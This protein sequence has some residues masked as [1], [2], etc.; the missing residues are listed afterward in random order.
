M[1]ISAVG[2]NFN[3][4]AY[5]VSGPS[6]VAQSDA[7]DGFRQA[8]QNATQAQKDQFKGDMSAFFKA[9]Q[10]GDMNAAQQA[11]QAVKQDRAAIYSPAS[12]SSA[13]AASSTGSSPDSAFQAIVN[14]VTNG[15]AQGAQA[16][17][18]KLQAGHP[19]GHGGH[20]HHHHGGGSQSSA[21]ATGGVVA[22]APAPT[23]G[24]D[25]DG[26]NDGR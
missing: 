9:V 1:S 14:A 7:A 17:L 3:P 26:D 4:A 21:A 11:L 19:G 15:D 22:A 23:Q 18:A 13:S 16:A 10:G 5:G 6:G 20:G 12:T 8:L 25:A 2:S 24:T